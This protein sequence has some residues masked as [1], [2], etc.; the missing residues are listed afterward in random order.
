MDIIKYIEDYKKFITE[1]EGTIKDNYH[2]DDNIYDYLGIIFPKKGLLGKYG[3]TFHGAG[4]RVISENIICEY[5]FLDYDEK[6]SYQFSLWKLK[7]FIESYSK[8]NVNQIELK[9]LLEEKVSQNKLKKLV[10]D[11][12]TFEIYLIN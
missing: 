1:F 3:Y 7:T 4:C 2:I 6:Y 10:I 5:D 12:R 11:G 8:K 9:N